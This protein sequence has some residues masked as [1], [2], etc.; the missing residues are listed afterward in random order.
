MTKSASANRYF[1]WMCDRISGNGYSKGLDF[2]KLLAHLHGIEFISL[3]TLDD[4]V[5]AAG[6]ELRWRYAYRNGLTD[7]PKS[8]DGP[9][10]VFEMILA[11]AMYCEESLMD[12]PRYGDRTR[13]WFWGMINNLGL[14]SMTDDRFDEDYVDEVIDRFMHRD[15]EPNGRGG[16][17]TIRN[18]DED[19]REVEIYHQLYWYLNSI[20]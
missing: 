18:C 16:L 7:V 11:L 6:V 19:L 8:L 12:D 9:C 3:M 14:G 5:A 17:F 13:Q 10:T 4:N 2:G 1:K 20:T 15:Y